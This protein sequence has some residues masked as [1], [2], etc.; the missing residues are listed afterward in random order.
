MR[1]E[2][3]IRDR[4]WKQPPGFSGRLVEGNRRRALSQPN[5]WSC[6]CVDSGQKFPG[7]KALQ[8]V[9]G[10][11]DVTGGNILFGDIVAPLHRSGTGR[12]T[13]INLHN[14]RDADNFWDTCIS[15]EPGSSQKQRT[16]Q[17]YRIRGRKLKHRG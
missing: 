10:V 15:A 6:C 17:K 16:R 1:K 4:C 7:S 8:E 11:T 9:S 2:Q 12:S 3:G 13:G 5:K 14:C